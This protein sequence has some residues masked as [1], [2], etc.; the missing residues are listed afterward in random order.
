MYGV[1]GVDRP[2]RYNV[3][4]DQEVGNDVMVRLVAEIMGVEPLMEFVDFHSSRPGHD[5]RYALDGSKLQSLGWE[6]PFS[7]E[8]GLRLTVE[9]SL[10]GGDIG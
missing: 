10:R 2:D 7:F 8:E 3:V 9:S 1:H 4:G 5:R 6:Q